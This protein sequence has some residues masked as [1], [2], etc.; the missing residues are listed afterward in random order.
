MRSAWGRL[1][2]LAMRV[3]ACL[4]RRTT[5]LTRASVSALRA[6]GT[7]RKTMRH[8]PR[9]IIGQVASAGEYHRV[10]GSVSQLRAC[11]SRPMSSSAVISEYCVS[12][13]NSRKVHSRFNLSSVPTQQAKVCCICHIRRLLRASVKLSRATSSSLASCRWYKRELRSRS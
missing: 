3:I 6:G 8:R 10:R 11:I 9:M 7:S 12:R 2:W 1:E 4:L 13:S 5:G